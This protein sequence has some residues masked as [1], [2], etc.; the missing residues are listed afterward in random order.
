MGK[1]ARF[2]NEG[3]KR[4]GG[5]FSFDLLLNCFVVS[6]VFQFQTITKMQINNDDPND[7]LFVC[8]L[9]VLCAKKKSFG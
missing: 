6:D 9:M 5:A 2:D 1:V 7:T 4:G 8:F 3:N